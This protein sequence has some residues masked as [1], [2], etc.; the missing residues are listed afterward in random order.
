[1]SEAVGG[2][3]Q[4]EVLASVLEDVRDGLDGKNGKRVS[5]GEIVSTLNDR[6][7]GALCAV[8]GLLAATPVIGALPGASIGSDI[9]VL[10]IAGQH[11]L[12]RNHLWIPSYLSK[13]SFERKTFENSLDTVR[14]YARRVDTVVKPRLRWF[15]GGST[16]RR[17]VAVAICILALTML[18]LALIPWGVLPPALAITAFRIAITGRDGLFA[19]LGYCL[20]ALTV[21][22]LYAFS[23]AIASIL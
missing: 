8:I 4:Q 20:V 14:P 2:K 22:V 5:V 6:G 9:L 21:Y 18:P 11:V 19:L 17:L 12:G 13:R 16:E 7:F 3:D 10:L 1:M 15:I 23:G